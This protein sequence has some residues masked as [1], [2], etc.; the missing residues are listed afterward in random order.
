MIKKIISW[1]VILACVAIWVL[2]I[3]YGIEP[4]KDIFGMVLFIIIPG[5]GILTG[6]WFMMGTASKCVYCDDILDDNFTVD[7]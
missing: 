1:I 7:L 3:M 2:L 6:V 5:G 4:T